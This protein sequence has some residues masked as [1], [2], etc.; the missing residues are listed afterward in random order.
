[1]M[2]AAAAAVIVDGAVGAVAA[3]PFFPHQRFH[4]G[5]KEGGSGVPRGVAVVQ[6]LRIRKCRHS[7]GVIFGI[8]DLRWV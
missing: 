8:I 6:A 4:Q 1:M 5:K 7:R 3:T 2:A